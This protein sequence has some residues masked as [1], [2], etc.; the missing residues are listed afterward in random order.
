MCCILMSGSMLWLVC[1][2]ICVLFWF[3]V[4]CLAVHVG[5]QSTVL[6][7]ALVFS[8]KVDCL[9]FLMYFEF[10]CSM[11]GICPGHIVV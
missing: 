8:H 11:C 7:S 10:R 6:F 3:V 5:A 9:L 4:L 2:L 1:L